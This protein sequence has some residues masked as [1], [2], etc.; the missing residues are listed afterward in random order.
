MWMRGRCVI[1]SACCIKS[2]LT[3]VTALL[4]PIL[5]DV[6]CDNTRELIHMMWATAYCCARLAFVLMAYSCVS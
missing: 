4:T 1:V 2:K 5:F 3:S 6:S